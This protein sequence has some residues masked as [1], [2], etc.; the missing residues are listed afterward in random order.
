M[1]HKSRTVLP[2]TQDHMTLSHMTWMLQKSLGRS[3]FNTGSTDLT[4]DPSLMDPDVHLLAVSRR[5]TNR[6]SKVWPAGVAI[7]GLKLNKN[8]QD[9][10][11]PSVYR[12]GRC[13]TKS[14]TKPAILV[15]PSL[16]RLVL[17]FLSFYPSLVPSTILSYA[18]PSDLLSVL[19]SWPTFVPLMSS[20]L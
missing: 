2:D 11:A 13:C 14:V 19:L 1:T 12:F 6:P 17:L 3:Y 15:L 20:V 7:V 18:C 10:R 5:A 9:V 16:H 8:F 4:S